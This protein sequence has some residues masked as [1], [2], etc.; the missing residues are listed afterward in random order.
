M[1]ES[2]VEALKQREPDG[3]LWV[4]GEERLTV[5]EVLAK[6]KVWREAHD[7]FRGRSVRVGRMTSAELAFVLCGLDGWA[8]ELR[9]E[10]DGKVV[11]LE[12]EWAWRKWVGTESCL[13][14]R[15]RGGF[16]RHQAPRLGCLPG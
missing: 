7:S 2:L 14:V 16:C 1:V 4:I 10:W 6:V 13:A 12:M 9:L 5:G 8:S 11:G 3:L 15:Q